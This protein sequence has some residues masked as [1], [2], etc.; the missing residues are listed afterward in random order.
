[1]VGSMRGSA[2]KAIWGPFRATLFPPF[3][4][5]W[6]LQRSVGQSRRCIASRDGLWTRS[7]VQRATLRCLGAPRS[8]LPVNQLW[9]PCLKRT[10]PRAIVAASCS[11]CAPSWPPGAPAPHRTW[12]QRVVAF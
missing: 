1:M 9:L 3:P 12:D 8:T 7:G 6:L 5:G 10:V 2:W 11:V 4:G